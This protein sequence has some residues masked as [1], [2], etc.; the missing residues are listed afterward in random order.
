MALGP[1]DVYIIGFPGNQ[2]T[3]QIAPELIELINNGTIRVI[4]ILLVIKDAE[5]VVTSIEMSDLD[6]AG[7]PSFMSVDIA[8]PGAL[9]QDDAEEISD[10][11]PV[12]SSALLLAFENVWASKLVGAMQGAEAYV[13]DYIRIPADVAEAVI[14]A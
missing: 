8:Q 6:S 7:G 12:N 4:D 10:D 14:T 3:G 11:L 5:G 9:G 13:I 1:V 2:F